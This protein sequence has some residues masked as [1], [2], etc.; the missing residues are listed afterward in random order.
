MSCLRRVRR[1]K[2]SNYHIMRISGL[3]LRLENQVEKRQ[4]F[5]CLFDEIKSFRFNN[6]KILQYSI[7]C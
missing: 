3:I 4:N 7:K 2:K 6:I 1:A 5:F